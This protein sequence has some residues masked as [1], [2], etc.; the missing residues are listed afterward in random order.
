MRRLRE[1]LQHKFNPLHVY[2][3]LVSLG[4]QETSARRICYAYEGLVYKRTWLCPH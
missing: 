2:C 4:F 1:F 3:R